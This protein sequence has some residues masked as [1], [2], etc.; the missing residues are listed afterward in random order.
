[1]ENVGATFPL[2]TA[3]S[4]LGKITFERLFSKEEGGQNQEQEEGM[5]EWVPQCG[6]HTVC[7]GLSE[8]FLE[9]ADSADSEP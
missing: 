2:P 9:R 3:S 4:S 1:M 8:L 6:L 5:S 7:I